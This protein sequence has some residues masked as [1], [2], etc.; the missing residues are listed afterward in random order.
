LAQ[1]RLE[2]ALRRV[3]GDVDA[4]D[5]LAVVLRI[6]D[7]PETALSKLD[8]ALA[9]APRREG[10]LQRAALYAGQLDRYDDALAYLQKACQLNPNYS[11]YY[12]LEG[13]V[14]SS[15]RD[16]Q[17]AVAAARAALRLNPSKRE[18]RKLLLTNLLKLGDK[19]EA[20][21]ELAIYEQFRTP[22][23]DVLRQRLDA[24]P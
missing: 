10:T 21:R 5:A 9:L 13:E 1:P 24:L 22:D 4:L 7:R 15:K 2:A 14:Y 17:H 16:G 18:F 20:R 8:E 12:A 6:L 19:T 3:P 11:L 23:V